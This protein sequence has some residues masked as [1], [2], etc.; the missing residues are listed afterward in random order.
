M[1]TF[2]N[3]AKSPWRKLKSEIKVYQV[4]QLLLSKSGL[5][6]HCYSLLTVLLRFSFTLLMTK[7][8]L[9]TLDGTIAA[10]Q[11]VIDIFIYGTIHFNIIS[12]YRSTNI[13]KCIV[14]YKEPQFCF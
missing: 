5:A 8:I 7:S 3:E 6:L 12:C 11:S 9:L 4:T 13:S 14:V 2:A 1:I 10:W